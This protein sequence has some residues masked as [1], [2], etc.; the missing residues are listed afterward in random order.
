MTSRWF[1]DRDGEPDHPDHVDK[2]TVVGIDLGD[3]TGLVR[4]RLASERIPYAPPDELQDD[5][6]E[7]TALFKPLILNN[8]DSL[9]I[10]MEYDV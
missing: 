1:L 5:V 8:G 9:T 2:V 6:I 4:V 3:P 10:T 7:P